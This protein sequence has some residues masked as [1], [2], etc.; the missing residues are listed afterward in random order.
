MLDLVV[1]LG[2]GKVLLFLIQKFPWSKLPFI[3]KLF[4]EGKFLEQLLSCDLCAGF[5]LYSTLAFIYDVNLITE[6]KYVFVISNILTGALSTFI[7]HLLSAG[8]KS[9]Y[10]VYLV[11]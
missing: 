9:L 8:W 3:G 2:T 6:L 5:W 11:E 1:F 10:G 7:V 4:S